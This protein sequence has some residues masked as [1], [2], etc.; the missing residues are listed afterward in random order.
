MVIQKNLCLA[1][2]SLNLFLERKELIEGTLSHKQVSYIYASEADVLNMALFG[3][4]AK[5]W[6]DENP[7]KE[8]NLRDHATIEHL[9]VLTNLESINAMLIHQDIKQPERLR[10]LNQMAIS[11][12]K[13]LLATKKKQHEKSKKKLIDGNCQK[14]L[15]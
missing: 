8:G 3:T 5:Q 4:T 11:Q 7:G 1:S 6:R 12:M 2:Y 15:L 14:G 13:S 10:Q 9:V